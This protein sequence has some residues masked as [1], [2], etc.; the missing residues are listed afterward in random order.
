MFDSMVL[1]VRRSR[2]VLT[3]IASLCLALVFAPGASALPGRWTSLAPVPSILSGVSGM[4]V[5]APV[6]GKLVAAYGSD[7]G[8]GDTNTTRIYNIASDTWSTGSDAPGVARSQGSAVSYGGKLYTLGGAAQS[9]YV[10]ADV[11]RYDPVTNTWRTLAPMPT[12]RAGLATAAVGGN[13]YAIGGRVNPFTPCQ[14]GLGPQSLA[15]ERYSVASG[16]WSSVAPMPN[17]RGD[18]A[19]VAVGR[20]IYVFGGC[21]ETFSPTGEVD[22]YDTVTNTWTSNISTMPAPRYAFYT[23]GAT[24]GRVWVIGGDDA[25]HTPSNANESYNPATNTWSAYAPMPERRAEMG[26][27]S[28]RGVIYTVGG[29][30]LGGGGSKL[31]ESFVPF[32]GPA[33]ESGTVPNGNLMA[34]SC[35]SATACTAVGT[36]S[37]STSGARLTLA[38]HWNGMS[39]TVQTT[40]N[41]SAGAAASLSGVSCPSTRVC[42]AVGSVTTFAGRTFVLA[43]HWNGTAWAVQAIPNPPGDTDAALA[44]VSCTSAN[45]CI[46]VG[47]STNAAGQPVALAERWNGTTWAIQPTPDPTG[48]KLTGVSCTSARACTA[49]GSGGSSPAGAAERWNGAQWVLQTTPNLGLMAGGTLDAVSCPSVSVCTATGSVDLGGGIPVPLAERWNGASW[50]VQ[51]T[52]E[53]GA[54]SELFGVSCTSASACMG[55]GSA[56][57]LNTGASTIFSERWSGVRWEIRATAN[58][59][60]GTSPTLSGVSCTSANACTAVGSYT[61]STTLTL[62]ERWNGTTWEIQ[63]TP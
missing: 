49:V 40:P 2:V 61:G 54:F 38:E 56:V 16:T 63:P 15:V 45:A 5:G 13:I 8:F 27:T 18:L 22:V 25:T 43:E 59:S 53:A 31:T 10:I 23:L 29:V 9:G 12:P 41:P 3:V 60:G 50:A 39:W 7:I 52:P 35:P 33:Q 21:D 36:G 26:V 32:A 6:T 57:D 20:K 4:Y 28:Q 11:D 30:Q 42:F 46:A 48:T 34:A 14:G 55:V 17:P 51:E 44:A 62:A 58:P 37:I 1:C 24:R 47:S 19:A